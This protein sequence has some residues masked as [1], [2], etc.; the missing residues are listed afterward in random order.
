MISPATQP[1]HDEH[2]ARKDYRCDDP[3]STGCTRTIVKGDIY[4]QLSYPPFA[5]PWRIPTWTIIRGCSTCLPPE[6]T[7]VVACPIGAGGDTCLLVDGHDGPH[8]YPATL[9]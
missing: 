6:T 7:T 9:F 2:R 5:P 4:V 8:D 1:K 3:A